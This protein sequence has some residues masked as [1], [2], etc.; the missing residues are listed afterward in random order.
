MHVTGTVQ[1]MGYAGAGV[2]FDV[3]ATAAA[4]NAIQFTISGNLAGC[5]LELHIQTYSQKPVGEGGGCSAATCRDYPRVANVA[6]PGTGITVPFSSMTSWTAAA[7][8]EVVGVYWQATVP[9][10]GAACP[11]DFRIDDLRFVTQ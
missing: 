7:G 3:C 11:F 4:F 6:A 1:P 9:S 5:V 10:G 8:M 2:A